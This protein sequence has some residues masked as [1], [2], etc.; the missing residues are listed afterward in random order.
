MTGKLDCPI[1][2][3]FDGKCCTDDEPCWCKPPDFSPAPVIHRRLFDTH[4][5]LFIGVILMTAAIASIT[6]AP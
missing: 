3:E 2:H 5:W 4:L 6:F 1:F